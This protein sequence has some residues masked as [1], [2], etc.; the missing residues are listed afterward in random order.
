MRPYLGYTIL[1]NVEKNYIGTTE[2]LPFRVNKN[3]A[4][5]EYLKYILLSHDYLKKSELLMYGKEHPRIHPLDLLN[6]K[7]PCPD[8]ETQDK[9]IEEIKAQEDKNN[10]LKNQIGKLRKEIDE[11]IW[12]TI[13]NRGE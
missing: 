2:L 9:L 10:E 13:I 7:A 11:I 5:P 8:L 4:R 12:K 1:N 3:T 6:I